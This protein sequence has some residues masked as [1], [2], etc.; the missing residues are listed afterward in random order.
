MPPAYEGPLVWRTVF[1]VVRWAGL[2]VGFSKSCDGAAGQGLRV[3]KGVKIMRN[4][5]DL[6]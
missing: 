6:Q 5:C 4:V 3:V 1:H 2:G